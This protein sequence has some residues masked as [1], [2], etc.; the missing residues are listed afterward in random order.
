MNHVLVCIKNKDAMKVEILDEKQ[1]VLVTLG[2]AIKAGDTDC[3]HK[4]VQKALD[5][6]WSKQDILQV[7]S[8]ILGDKKLLASLTEV[9][10]SLSYEDALRREYLD[11]TSDCGE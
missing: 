3:L 8:F 7:V 10:I 4:Y 2:N 5:A 9:L 6:G 1:K 11:I